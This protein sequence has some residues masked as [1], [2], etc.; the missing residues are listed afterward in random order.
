VS[1]PEVEPVENLASMRPP[2]VSCIVP[3]FNGGRYLQPAIESILSQTGP[4][5]EIIV[6]DDGST[7]NSAEIARSFGPAVRYCYQVNRGVSAAR[8]RG[9]RMATGELIC[10]L[11]ADD[12]F[13]ER[14]LESQQ[15]QFLNRPEL[16]F[17]AGLTED[18]WSSD[19]AE[20]ERDHD[21]VM[22]APYPRHIG[23]WML[24]RSLFARIGDFDETMPLSQDVDWHLR[25][26]QAGTVSETLPLI[27][28]RRR[29]H[30]GNRTRSAR[31]ACR[32]AVMQSLNRHLLAPRRVSLTSVPR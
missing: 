12:L 24:R 30:S 19:V 31:D 16:E 2:A 20:N 1:L 9:V 5:P 29:L 22:Q 8:N 17:T 11:D 23:T 32:A 25:A 4:T 13:L 3:V 18:F 10:F 7:D 21:S 28:S 6:V 15:Q 26:M 14:K 27:L